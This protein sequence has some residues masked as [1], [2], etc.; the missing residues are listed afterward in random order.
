MPRSI[1]HRAPALR[2]ETPAAASVVTAAPSPWLKRRGAAP[3][4]RAAERAGF[5]PYTPGETG[6]ARSSLAA[7]GLLASDPG[8]LAQTGIGERDVRVSPL[9]MALIAA[10]I[11]NEGLAM[12][13][14]VVDSIRTASG[15]IVHHSDPAPLARMFAAGVAG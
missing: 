6:A 10:A 15:D 2:S 7:S 4:V 12:R 14:Y 13:P 9:H 11:G 8:A 5:D 3:S 1:W